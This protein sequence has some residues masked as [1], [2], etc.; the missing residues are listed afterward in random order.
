MLRRFAITA[1]VILA[2]LATS[3]RPASAQGPSCWQ[4]N[5]DGRCEVIQG[6]ASFGFVSCI[7]NLTG[8]C[9]LGDICVPTLKLTVINVRADGSLSGKLGSVAITRRDGRV[10]RRTCGNKIVDRHYSAE[11]GERVRKSTQVLII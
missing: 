1:V 7:N 5:G 8:G 4:C 10:F 3:P 9:T 6:N 2:A 11:A